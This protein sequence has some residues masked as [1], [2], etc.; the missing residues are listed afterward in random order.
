MNTGFAQQLVMNAEKN[1]KQVRKKVTIM[2]RIFAG[3]IAQRC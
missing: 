3:L 2:L 1:A